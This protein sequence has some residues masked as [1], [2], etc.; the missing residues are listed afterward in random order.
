MNK[1][2]NDPTSKKVASTASRIH[3][4][5]G[6]IPFHMFINHADRHFLPKRRLPLNILN[7]AKTTN[8]LA[9]SP[10]GNYTD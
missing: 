5:S 7:E 8:S 6:W 10:Q 1:T 9:L 3:Q 4:Y 2:N